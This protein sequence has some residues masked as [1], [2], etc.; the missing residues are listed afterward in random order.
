ME[1]RTTSA[2]GT[3]SPLRS[4]DAGLL[5]AFTGLRLV[6]EHVHD[7]VGEALDRR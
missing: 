7:V 2:Q 1:S 6:V 5:A 4:Y 3:T